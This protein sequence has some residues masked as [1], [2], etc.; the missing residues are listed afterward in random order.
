[1]FD[2]TVSVLGDTNQPESVELTGSL[3]FAM[4]SFTALYVRGGKL[5]GAVLVNLAADDRTAEFE[6]LQ[7]AIAVGKKS[8]S[9]ES[10]SQT[11]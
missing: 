11:L 9:S 4:P 8:E 1:M 5:M 6:S 7:Q 10:K 3:D 2:V